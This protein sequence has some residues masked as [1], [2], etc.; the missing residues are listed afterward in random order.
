MSL[1]VSPY[2]MGSKSAQALAKAL[3]DKAG[4]KV[5]QVDRE[6]RTFQGRQR[7]LAINWGVGTPPVWAASVGGFV[8]QH[9]S[10]AI[11]SNKLATFNVLSN[12]VRQFLPE[13]TTEQAI[14]KG[15]Y[16]SGEVVVCRTVLNGH[17]GA[18]IV[19]ASSAANIALV[20]A[21]L[22]TKY[23][24]K[25][26]EFRVHVAFGQVIDTQEKRKR[27]EVPRE[28]INFQIRSHANG[29]VFCRE[30]IQK[31]EGLDALAI[32]A[33]SGLGLDFGAADIIFNERNNK[34]VV[35]EVNTAPGLEG[36]TVNSYC[37]AIWNKVHAR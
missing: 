4:R 9:R 25:S 26:K 12:T 24:K 28:N 23:V 2:K 27:Q 1:V 21:P 7:H 18:G 22:Y 6:S 32:A 10:V 19:I 20:P 15:W 16:D 30:G 8:N 17:S 3:S 13:F 14:A 36:G 34:L 11:A 37:N 5:F 29:W 31:P 35:L 33:V